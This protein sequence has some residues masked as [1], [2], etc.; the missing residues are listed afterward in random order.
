MKDFLSLI[1]IAKLLTPTGEKA[2]E[3]DSANPLRWSVERDDLVILPFGADA[4]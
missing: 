3:F 4:I 2:P 1:L